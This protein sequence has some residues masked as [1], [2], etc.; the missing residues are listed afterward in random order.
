MNIS[1]LLRSLP[2][3][4]VALI[5][6]YTYQ[7]Q[8][9]ILLEDIRD[10]HS[11]REIAYDIYSHYWTAYSGEHISQDKRWLY[12]DLVFQANRTYPIMHGYTDDF[13]KIW[14]RNPQFQYDKQK[15]DRF[16]VHMEH[17]DNL[18]QAINL[19]FGILTPLERAQ[20]VTR[21]IT[22]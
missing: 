1:T 7:P 14:F 21:P 22:P 6:P 9:R 20:L 3:E 8:S 11:S 16:V 19:Y 17:D 2:A 5:I 18:D 13:Y 10:F 15:V 12:N 4:V